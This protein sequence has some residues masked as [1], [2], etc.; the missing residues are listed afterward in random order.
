M[1]FYEVKDV[2]EPKIC[3]YVVGHKAFEMPVQ[4]TFYVPLMVGDQCEQ[5]PQ[6]GYADNIGENISAKN[7]R[8]NEL[9]GLYWIWKNS[10]AEIVGMCHYRRYFVT[11]EGK[12][13]NV[14]FGEKTGFLDSLYIRKTLSKYDV[15]LHNKTLTL[16]GNQ[17]QLCLRK[18]QKDNT[19]KNK[20]D[21]RI[22]DI[23]DNIFESFYPQDMKIYRLVMKRKYA[24]LLNM[25][26]CR[27]KVVDRY[28]EWLF[29]LLEGIEEQV[30]RRYP[31]SE[32]ERMLGLLAERLLDVWVL[33]EKLRVKECF[34][35]N[36]ENV[37]WKIW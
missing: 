2:S 17:N 5:L 1:K 12:I 37:D 34:T 19:R 29:P 4:D 14:L 16:K 24:H 33:K 23:S 3:I 35:L 8:Y 26:I 32:Q 9:T 11:L 7:K 22:L 30:E 28:C 18:D 31:E 10:D 20:L 25:M 15:I 21:R 6:W 36:V 13:R 27:K